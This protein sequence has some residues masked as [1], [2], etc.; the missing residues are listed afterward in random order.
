G[1]AVSL[2][3]AI[4]VHYYAS[5]SMVPLGIAELWRNWRRRR[6]DWPLWFA[7]A[8]PVLLLAGHL[9]LI[10]AGLD[11]YGHH[12]PAAYTPSLALIPGM[13]QAL[14]GG[15]PKLLLLAALTLIPATVA[16]RGTISRPLWILLAVFVSLPLLAIALGM[17]FG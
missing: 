7:F 8:A 5:V 9:P 14:L 16:T 3:L 1:L 10:R 6:I 17:S 12:P 15:L 11:C 13:F 4:S 2:T